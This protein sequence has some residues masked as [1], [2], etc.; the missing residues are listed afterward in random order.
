MHTFSSEFKYCLT[1][2]CILHFINYQLKFTPF[3][4]YICADGEWYFAQ[5]SMKIKIYYR[6]KYQTKCQPDHKNV[7]QR[8]KR[9]KEI[10]IR[11][12]SAEITFL[13]SAVWKG[14]FL[15]FILSRLS[16]PVIKFKSFHWAKPNKNRSLFTLHTQ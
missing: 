14:V 4:I 2:F 1:R 7:S 8:S 15:I 6:K 3:Q 12:K 9:S 16:F 13:F 10:A 5:S 11:W